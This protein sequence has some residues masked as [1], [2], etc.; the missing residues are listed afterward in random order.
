MG[1]LEKMGY[2]V[3][4]KTMYSSD[5]DDKLLEKQ[6]RATGHVNPV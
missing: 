2:T 1:I 4:Y 5:K 6:N 3:E